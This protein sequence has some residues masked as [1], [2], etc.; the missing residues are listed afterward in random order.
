MPTAE[1]LV[2]SFTGPDSHTIDL[3]P[4]QGY[5]TVGPPN[6]S[7]AQP[8]VIVDP[9]DPIDWSVL[10]QFTVPAGYPW[11]RY[12]TYRGNDTSFLEWAVNRPIERFDWIPESAVSVDAS[13]ANISRF[14]IQLSTY[15]VEVVVPH[16]KDGYD[17]FSVSGDLSLFM[18]TLAAGTRAPGF[19]NFTPGTLLGP[20]SEP[21]RLPDFPAFRDAIKIGV[22]GEPLR[23]AIDCASLLQFPK[24]MGVSMSGRLANLAALAELP[25]LTSLQVRNCPD[26]SSFPSL[27]SFVKLKALM[28]SSID[29]ANGKRIR[30]EFRKLSKNPDRKWE[31]SWVDELRKPAW[32]ITEY[33]LPFGEWPTKAGRVATKTYR[34]AAASIAKATSAADVEEAIRTFVR[35]FNTQPDIETI[36]RDDLGDAVGLLATHAPFGVTPDLAQTWFDEERDY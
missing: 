11:P 26:M 20:E 10:N 3:S 30:S 17:T 23:Q 8:H 29:E 32:F 31:Q 12:I 5:L 15:P 28:L 4:G 22:S 35:F 27:E 14:A 33:G 24:T 2:L 34:A 19:V 6:P 9:D 25:E 1:P 36:E 21:W 7:G 18:P 16:S 13:K